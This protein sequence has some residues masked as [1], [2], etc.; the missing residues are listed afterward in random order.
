[1]SEARYRF[2]W[3][4]ADN[5][6]FRVADGE[7]FMGKINIIDW[8]MDY[9]ADDPA[10]IDNLDNYYAYQVIEL[11]T[12]RVIHELNGFR[13]AIIDAAR[14]M[15]ENILGYYSGVDGYYKEKV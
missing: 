7:Q 13:L 11:K 15:P 1:M 4:P 9:A 8:D 10:I 12:G 6:V 2:R 14:S 3:I 5:H